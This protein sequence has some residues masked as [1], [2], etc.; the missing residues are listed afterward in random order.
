MPSN[1]SNNTGN[2]GNNSGSNNI[3]YNQSDV[4]VCVPQSTWN[5]MQSGQNGGG[6]SQNAGTVRQMRVCSDNAGGNNN[7]G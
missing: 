5:N 7:T 3:G 6:S 1:G 4:M 2:S